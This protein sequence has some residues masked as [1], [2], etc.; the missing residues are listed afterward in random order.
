[1]LHEV[2][3]GQQEAIFILHMYRI[4]SSCN[5]HFH[6]YILHLNKH[7]CEENGAN[8]MKYEVRYKVEDIL[9]SF[10]YN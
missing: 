1:M 7:I 8:K 2:K 3:S 5:S 4:K 10:I 6:D 9:C